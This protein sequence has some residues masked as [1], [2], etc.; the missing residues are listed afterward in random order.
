M[1]YFEN[2]T[3]FFCDGPS[4]VTLGK[5]DGLHRGH[6][7]LI[8]KITELKKEGLEAVVF[9]LAPAV[10]PYL[11]SPE[12]KRRK[13]EQ[14]IEEQASELQDLETEIQLARVGVRRWV[15]CRIV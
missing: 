5:F 9:S 14:T 12:E 8:R 4:A 3:D 10:R 1:K 2:T 15:N 11:L 6:Q 13:G 7:K